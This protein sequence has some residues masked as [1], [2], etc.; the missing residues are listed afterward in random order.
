MWAV[1]FGGD[2]NGDLAI[3]YGISYGHLLVIIN[4]LSMGLY[5]SYM[6]ITYRF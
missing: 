5:I 1:D 4:W 6:V 2:R 3:G